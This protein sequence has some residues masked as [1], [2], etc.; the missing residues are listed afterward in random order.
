VVEDDRTVS[1]G[2]GAAGLPVAMAGMLPIDDVLSRLGSSASGLS[3]DEAAQ[4]LVLAGPNAVRTHHVRAWAVLGRQLRSAL[5]VLLVG[6]ATIS[7]FLGDRTNAVIIGVIL[8]ASVGLGFV[9]E[10]R[11]ERAAQALHSEIRHLAVVVR[12]GQASQVD[13]IDMVPGDVV[14]LQL[15]AVVP[16]D[17]RLLES[18]GLE[19]VEGVLT[20]ESLPVDKSTGPVVAGAALADLSSCALMGT[21][22]SAGAGVGV[23]VATGA[24]TE[25]GRIALGLGQRPPETAFQAGL[26]RFSVLLLVVAMVLTTA[27]FAINLLLHR[28]LLDAA[29]FSLAIA[30]GI[31]P[32][33]LPA[34]VSTSLATG[35][36]RLA[37]RKVLVKRLVCIEDLGDMDVLVTDKTGTLTEGTISFTAAVDQAGDTSDRLLLFGLLATEQALAGG[38]QEGANPLDAALWH[39]PRAGHDQL[40]EY[41]RLGLVPFD[42]QRRMTSALIQAPD[43]TRLLIV[44]GAPESVL[45]HCTEV[46]DTAHTILQDLFAAGSRVVAVAS[47]PAPNLT[48]LSVTDE[49]DLSLDGFLVFVDQP[50]ANAAAS[51][52]TSASPSR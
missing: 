25:F 31:T 1:I 9:N 43:H 29:L 20:G 42:H 14:R 35:S 21:V 37:R 33:L 26:R 22:V 36:R 6:T 23:V 18:N 40:D 39:A 2:R 7:F 27:I 30:V 41:R 52:L 3:S 28:P 44:K 12:D 13:V 4:R 16:A 34:V 15:G 49:Q 46:P 48:T 19:C 11:A 51:L 47:R 32:Q 17:L 10:Y 8:V 38:G 24:S 5:L 45:A 50:K